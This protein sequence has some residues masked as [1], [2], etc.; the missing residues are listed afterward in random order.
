M[1][2]NE[3][4]LFSNLVVFKGEPTGGTIGGRKLE[5]RCKRN[6]NKYI[7]IE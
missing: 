7:I 1:N 3:D 6:A 2:N 4:F 5:T